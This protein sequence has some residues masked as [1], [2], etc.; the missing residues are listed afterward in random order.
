M[1]NCRVFFFLIKIPSNRIEAF[2]IEKPLST[3]F[4][5]SPDDRPRFYE[6]DPD[7]LEERSA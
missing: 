2:G 5:I 4:A 6:I 1:G 7:E 3:R